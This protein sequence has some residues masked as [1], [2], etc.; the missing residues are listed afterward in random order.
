MEQLRQVGEAI[1]GVNAVMAIFHDDL[2]LRCVNP[3]QCALLAH[4]YSL[5]FHAIAGDLRSRLRLA[6]GAAKWKP[7]EDPLRELH[8][9]IRDGEGYIRRCLIV[10]GGSWWART[11][12][13]THGVECVERHLHDLLWCVAVVVDAIELASPARD[14]EG[15]L[16]D[17]EIFRRRLGNTYLATAELA[18]RIDIAWKEDRWLLSHLLD[19]RRNG[20]STANF[21]PSPAALTTLQ[22]HRLA[23]VLASPRG[24]L[25]PATVLHVTEFQ[26]RRRLGGCMKEA[27]WMG[28]SFAVKH[29]VGV[30]GDDA[31][32]VAAAAASVSPHPN[33]AH[34]R[35]CF[36]DE[37]KR[38]MFVVMDDDHLT[39][40]DLAVFVKEL[41]SGKRRS[42]S[43]L[44][45]LVVVDAMLQIARGMEHL[46]SKRIYH[47]NLIPSNVLV[48]P[49]HGEGYLHVKVAGIGHGES[50]VSNSGKKSTAVNDAIPSCI[51]HA[52]E[53][54]GNESPPTAR[55]TEKGDVYSFGMICFELLTGKIPFEDNHLAGENMG[56]NILAGERPLFPFQ[57][58]K[59]LTSLTRRCWH[60]DPSQ[61]PAFHSVCRVLRYL[62]RFLVINPDAVAAPA[63]APPVDYLDVEAQLL[64]RFPEWETNAAA[65]PRVAD[66]PFLMYAYRVMEREK[67]NAMV[68]RE[69]SSDSGSDG[70]SSLCG[71]DCVNGV[72][73]T[74][75]VA[76][77]QPASSRTSL[78]NRNSGGGG[79]WSSPRKVNGGKGIA[80]AAAVI[81]AGKCVFAHLIVTD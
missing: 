66:V 55:C 15:I 18:A 49:L 56:K 3:R 31:A 81:K 52:P 65:R 76:D 74:T 23:D 45:L 25:H 8:R 29:L 22:E 77:T 10:N 71:D 63:T 50:I 54:M 34:S 69:R 73:V 64:R 1:G 40:K 47:G 16:L 28:E 79:R 70:N 6:A 62:K 57:T 13:A 4:A 39:C 36:H 67:V 30:D 43:S 46:H 35:Y 68:N 7:L 26:M 20:C 48:K 51:W 75:T 14:D 37:E 53:L 9:V 80:A 27:N 19:E 38:E 2:P 12:A 11:A 5:A 41:T 24:K 33:V 32:A 60:G 21:S 17:L 59:Y 72:S 78:T 61:R 44:P 42:P 58:P